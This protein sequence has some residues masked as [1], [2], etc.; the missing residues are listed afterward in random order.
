[1]PSEDA[2][3]ELGAAPASGAPSSAAGEVGRVQSFADGAE[4]T[5]PAGMPRDEKKEFADVQVVELDLGAAAGGGARDFERVLAENSIALHQ[6]A[7]TPEAA[8]D[9]AAAASLTAGNAILV[10]AS[11]EQLKQILSGYEGRAVVVG[12]AKLSKELETLVRQKAAGDPSSANDVKALADWA[13]RAA[14]KAKN[15]RGAS[16]TSQSGEAW[17]LLSGVDAQARRAVQAPVRVA[18]DSPAST[19]SAPAES[20]RFYQAAPAADTRRAAV[21]SS[22][23]D[24]LEAATDADREPLVRVLFRFRP[25]AEAAAAAPTSADE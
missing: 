19:S 16:R 22:E 11:P 18:P 1:M 15:V 5:Q 8:E 6:E 17:R 14:D 3:A 9:D 13:S 10:E 23:L 2:L 24:R 21:R 4:T 25:A 12:E 7:L 20:S